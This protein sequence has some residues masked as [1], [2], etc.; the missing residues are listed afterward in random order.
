M[1]GPLAVSLSKEDIMTIQKIEGIS[2][3]TEI[4]GGRAAFNFPE[5][6]SN[7]GEVPKSG[8]QGKYSEKTPDISKFAFKLQEMDQQMMGLERKV[9][10][11][12]EEM[13]SMRRSLPPFPPGSEER[14]RILKGYIGLR[15]LI[16]RLTIPREQ[17]QERFLNKIGLPELGEE[18]SDPEVDEAIKGLEKAAQTIARERTSLP[19]E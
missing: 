5:T 10:S 16:E 3:I 4:Q 7:T 8:P 9:S 18:A 1:F 2:S 14:V 12:K 6:R 11:I 15:K 19:G 17:N 13:I